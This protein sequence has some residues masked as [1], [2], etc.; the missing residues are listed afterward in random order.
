MPRVTVRELVSSFVAGRYPAPLPVATRWSSRDWGSGRAARSRLSGGQAQ[1]VRFAVA[2]AGN[3]DLIVLDEPTA[4]LDVEARRAFWDSMRSYARRGHTVLFSTHYLQEADAHADRILVID[5]GR[6]V[7]D[8][9]GEQLKRSVGGNLVSFDLAGRGTE[10]L[11]RR[12]VWCRWRCAG[13]GPG[14]A[15]TTRTPTVLALAELGAIRGLEVVPAS[16]DDA[17]MALTSHVLET[18]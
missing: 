16:L 8:G 2:L 7:A 1:R 17:F 13:T 12:P 3:P 11:I 9:T 4:A 5:H 14:C 18:V 10:G 6:L 15:R